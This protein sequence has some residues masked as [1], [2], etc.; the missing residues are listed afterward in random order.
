MTM[1]ATGIYSMI[2]NIFDFMLNAGRLTGGK[3]TSMTITNTS[4]S[5]L[6]NN[7]WE[8][9]SI[10]CNDE[11]SDLLLFRRPTLDT[12]KIRERMGKK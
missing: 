11:Q 3:E 8:P 7:I 12:L 9:E 4:D 1:H 10:G 2:H 5:L 6:Q